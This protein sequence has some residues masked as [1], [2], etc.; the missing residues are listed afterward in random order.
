MSLPDQT[1]KRVPDATFK[2][3]EGYQWAEKTT[4]DF[5]KGKK[6]VL[7]ALPGAFTPTCSSTHLP[8]YNELYEAFKDAGVD[9]VVCLSVNDSFV[10]N[11][12]KRDQNAT[13]ITM[14]PDGNGEFS[15][16]LGFL[17]DKSELGFGKRSWRYSM[18]VNDGVIE[19]MF[20]E[21][22]KP[23]DPFSQSDADT[24]LK[25]LDAKIPQSVTMFTRPGCP[26]CA[27]AAELL[28]K[29]NLSYEEHV[30]NRDFSIKTLVALSGSTM[31]PQV[32]IQGERIGG[33]EE[34]EK[35]LEA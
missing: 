4:D 23:G 17:V 25:Y 32:F 22:E 8:R 31:V 35:H 14:L 33:A 10:M 21:E 5:F 24:M 11:D 16:K 12:W 26:F 19:K 27:K 1:G 9:D 28:Q 30:L 2:I 15:E 7:F 18:L 3:R 34:L 6:V 13:N 29:H 20:I